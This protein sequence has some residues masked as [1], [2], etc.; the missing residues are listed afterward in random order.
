MALVTPQPV[1][2]RGRDGLSWSLRNLPK[3]TPS[4]ALQHKS[5]LP[6]WLPPVTSGFCPR[7]GPAPEAH[8]FPA[9]K[10]NSRFQPSPSSL[11]AASQPP[12]WTFFP[13]FPGPT[14]AHLLHQGLV[15]PL[16]CPP[17][18]TSSLAPRAR[19]LGS[20]PDYPRSPAL[21]SL[22][23]NHSSLTPARVPPTRPPLKL[24]THMRL[25]C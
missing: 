23:T 10:S 6:A 17:S 12:G 11:G 21:V 16:T 4:S 7:S 15:S 5:T 3:P 24:Q 8:D 9:A 13:R 22:E 1:D 25:P 19:T 2:S 20:A 18:P 14:S